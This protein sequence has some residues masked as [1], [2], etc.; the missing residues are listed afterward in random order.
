[1]ICP[2][3]FFPIVSLSFRASF[4]D[5]L[6]DVVPLVS[7]PKWGSFLVFLLDADQECVQLATLDE[8]TALKKKSKIPQI[9]NWKK[10]PYCNVCKFVSF[11]HEHAH[12]AAQ[13]A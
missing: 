6:I 7:D 12:T 8:M 3:D 2:L 10:N 4:D 9:H 11:R 13:L 5:G 1:L